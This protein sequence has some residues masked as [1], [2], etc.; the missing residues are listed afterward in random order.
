[1]AFA[2]GENRTPKSGSLPGAS[3]SEVDTASRE[4]NASKQESRASVLIQS[5]PTLQLSARSARRV[6]GAAGPRV[7]RFVPPPPASRP[8]QFFRLAPCLVNHPRLLHGPDDG[9][10][11]PDLAP[12]EVAE[13]LN[14]PHSKCGIGASLSGVRIPPSPPSILDSAEVLQKQAFLEPPEND[15]VAPWCPRLPLLRRESRK[16]S[17]SIP[18]RSPRPVALVAERRKPAEHVRRFG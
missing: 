14:A 5:E 4:E 3:S 13:W 12:G 1:M 8:K 17:R 15:G 2:R 9:G 18:D 6:R 16:P 7:R 10:L 11:G